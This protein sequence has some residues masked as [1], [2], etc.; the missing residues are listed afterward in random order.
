MI[1]SH[2]AE[3]L[4]EMRTRISVAA[5]VS[6]RAENQ[7]RLVAVSKTKPNED[8]LAAYNEGQRHFGENVGVYFNDYEACTLTL[9]I[10]PGTL[11]SNKCK[12]IVAIP[13]LFAVET[14]DGTKKADILQKACIQAQRV[15]P[16]NIFVQINTSGEESKS[17]I[18]P[19]EC[20]EVARHIAEKC[21]NLKLSGL[22]T[23]GA[24]NHDPA[25]GPNPDFQILNDCRDSISDVMK[26]ADIELSMGM[27]DDFESAIQMGSTNVRLGS[28]IFG[29]RGKKV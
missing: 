2:V 21:P 1:E 4:G 28:C 8:I 9:R 27:S 10:H 3:N 24:P 12:Q 13:N 20:P 15:E 26:G 16:L 22:M 11:Q 19:Q 29:A 17:G 23:I 5:A 7:V 25:N 6:G 14:V 18:A